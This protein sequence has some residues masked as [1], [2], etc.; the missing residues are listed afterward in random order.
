MFNSSRIF[1][2]KTVITLGLLLVLGIASDAFAARNYKMAG[3]WLAQRGTVGIPLQFVLTKTMTPGAVGKHNNPIGFPNGNIQGAGTVVA[4]GKSPASLTLPVSIFSSAASI[5]APGFPLPGTMNIQI[6]TNFSKVRAPG[7]VSKG[8]GP[9]QLV[10][11]GGPGVVTFCPK[12]PQGANRGVSATVCPGIGNPIAGSGRNG[13]IVYQPGTNQ[14]G[15]VMQMFLGGAGLV[16]RA[17]AG[18]GFG[19][20]T[21]QAGHN[22][23]GGGGG[24]LQVGGGAMVG[25][26]TWANE[27]NTLPGGPYTQPLNRPANTMVGFNLADAGPKLTVGGLFTT[28]PVGTGTNLTMCTALDVGTPSAPLLLAPTATTTNT[29][30]PFSTGVVFAQQ[31]TNTGAGYDYFTASGSDMRTPRG[32]GQITLVAGGLSIRKSLAGTTSTGAMETVNM[33][34]GAPVPTMTKT[35]FAAAAALMVI[36]VGYAFRRRF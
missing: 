31:N 29:G 36:A 11:S 35:G 27:A 26:K 9:A 16:T 32:V 14:F 13:R 3:D 34:I 17:R 21:F 5:A 4:T 7:P 20:A 12:G 19:D 23:F 24:D 33:Q 25:T 6:T 10:K 30:L 2:L 1:G 8:G 22:E 28:C 15:G 18:F